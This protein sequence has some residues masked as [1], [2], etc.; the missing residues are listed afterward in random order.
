M[1]SLI[2]VLAVALVLVILFQL[3]KA[4]ELLNTLKGE[5]EAVNRNNKIQASLFM[6]TLIFGMIAIF[7]SAYHYSDA[8][9]FLKEPAAVHSAKIK[10]MYFWTLLA[11]LPIFVL[12]H[13]LL[14]GFSYFYKKDDNR[15]A[16]Y[17]PENNKLELVWMVIP[18]IVM[19]LLVMEGIRSWTA[20]TSPA[21]KDRNTLVIEATAQQFKWDIRYS[22]N[23]GELGAK[24]V[25]L[26]DLESNPWGQDWDD[27]ANFDDFFA[28]DSIVL[29]VNRPILVKINALDVLHSFYLPDFNV[30]MDAVP[31]IPTQFWFEPTKTSEQRQEELNDPNFIYELAC[32]ELCGKAHFNMRR[33]VYVVE[34]DKFD[35][36]MKRQKPLYE[37][38]KEQ[39][40]TTQKE[41]KKEDSGVAGIVIK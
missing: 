22:G 16:K 41:E 32:T 25:P 13:I 31:G 3:A 36:W 15:L 19:V 20:I 27:K 12:T 30:K 14:F 4:G 21:P 9:L 23:D 1:Y 11:I 29:P 8:F 10:G 2:G 37:T 17:Y 34:E 18:A 7:W 40:A 28:P 26:M 39:A 5:D 33:E 35:A 38:L 24:R 6:L